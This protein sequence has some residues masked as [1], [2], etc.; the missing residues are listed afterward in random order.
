MGMRVSVTMV[1]AVLLALP[2]TAAADD[3]LLGGTTPEPRLLPQDASPD[4]EY[5]RFTVSFWSGLDRRPRRFD[6]STSSA[7]DFGASARHYFGSDNTSWWGID[8]SVALQDPAEPLLDR[9]GWQMGIAAGRGWA[10]GFD[11]RG[12]IDYERA[13]FNYQDLSMATQSWRAS[14][15]L[16]YS[17]SESWGVFAG[18]GYRRGTGNNGDMNGNSTWASDTIRGPGW[19][20]YQTSA[21]TV[22]FTFGAHIDLGPAT[23]FLVAWQRLDGR[24]RDTGLDFDSSVYR[25]QLQHGF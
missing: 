16:D 5:S 8:T 23:Q 9:Q 11:V 20:T 6:D 22:T 3:W 13:Q 12:R 1:I 7:S 18:L 21:R 15:E 2:V 14:A 4:G 19:R 24:V 25:F 17:W 10:S